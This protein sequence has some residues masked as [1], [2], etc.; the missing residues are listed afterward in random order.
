MIRSKADKR[1]ERAACIVMF[2][3]MLIILFPFLLLFM[4]SITEESSL[5]VNGYSI[6]PEE[7]SF[8]A[9]QY[10][11]ESKGTI[12]RA[13][14]I[15]ILVTVAGTAANVTITALAAYPLSLDK[16][17]GRRAI[18]FLILFTMLFNGGLVP[19]YM[20]YTTVLQIKNTYLALL[21]PNLMFS[22]FNAIIVRTYLRTNIPAELYESAR[23]DGASEFTIFSRIVLPLGKSIFVT[24]GIFSGLGYWNDWMNGLYYISD[25][26]KYPIQQLL[27]VMVQNIRFLTQYGRSTGG[28]K[29]PSISLRMAI[30]F[31]AMLPV[32]IVYP[33]LQKYFEKGVTLG[34]VK[35]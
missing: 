29:L 35:G 20:I 17:P 23:I 4:S 16:L 19:T 14:L 31:V 11:W 10:I 24:I 1:F 33:F 8:A 21:V 7:I 2:A 9:Y 32:L 12:L 25:S 3:I 26:S 30:A 27:N 22:A 18:S 28:D 15:T 5:L 6:F 13:Y 34:A